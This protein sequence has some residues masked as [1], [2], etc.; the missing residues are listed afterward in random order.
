M[1]SLM[2]EKNVGK[3]IFFP[4]LGERELSVLFFGSFSFLF[5][6][7]DSNFHTKIVLQVSC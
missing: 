2:N 5:Q 6:V 1:R 4:T 3:V 7:T